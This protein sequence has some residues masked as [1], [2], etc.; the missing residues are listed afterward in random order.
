MTLVT[1]PIFVI[2]T[3]MQTA[4]KQLQN[5]AGLWGSA[6]TPQWH[7]EDT[8]H[9]Y[10]T[11][12]HH[13]SYHHI[14][15]W[16]H[17]LCPATTQALIKQEGVRGMYRGLLPAL[18]LTCHGAVHWSVFEHFKKLLLQYS[19]TDKMVCVRVCV[20]CLCDV[21]AAQLVLWCLLYDPQGVITNNEEKKLLLIFFTEFCTNVF[22]GFEQ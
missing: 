13:T 20:C 1:N 17:W 11:S 19:A 10:I 3:R 21:C 9:H 5:S 22:G 4:N 6:I 15:R 18:P 12:L 14:A 8:S 7:H 16:S 2:K